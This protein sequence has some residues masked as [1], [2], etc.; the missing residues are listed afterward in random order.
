MIA[1]RPQRP[2]LSLTCG[3]DRELVWAEGDSVRYL[4]ADVSAAGTVLQDCERVPVNLALAIDVSGSMAGEKLTAARATAAA[5]AE[6][7]TA[8]DRLTLVAFSNHAELLLDACRMDAEGRTQAAAAI[9]KLRTIGSTNLFAGWDLAA[10]RVS[11]ASGADPRASHRVLML[12]DGLA[13]IGVTDAPSLARFAGDALRQNIITSAVGIGDDYDEV[14]LAAMTEAGGGRV[15]DATTGTEIHEVVLGE[16]LEGRTALVERAMLRVEWPVHAAKVEV[17]GP[18]S[19]DEQDG[20]ISVL[21]GSLHQDQ[22]RRVVLRVRCLGGPVG[23]SLDFRASLRAQLPDG[24][25]ELVTDAPPLALTCADGN[26]NGGQP[27]HVERS[28]VAL[29]AWQGA[30]MRHAMKLNRE[31]RRQEARH[32]LGNELRWITRYAQGLPGGEQILR[33]LELLYAQVDE[34]MDRRVVKEM[35]LMQRKSARGERDFRSRQAAGAEELLRRRPRR[36]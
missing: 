7:L 18:W 25:A 29:A 2:Q 33:E 9:A 15:H 26:A 5:V 6:A 8:D 11:H 23:G 24:S 12:T 34:E 20:T 14:L 30:A 16:L 1:Q 28:V 36:S 21:V 35:M 32:Y 19:S 3:P 22:V 4:V 10:G 31:G 13:N 27:R 17:V